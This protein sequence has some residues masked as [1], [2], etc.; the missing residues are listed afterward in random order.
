M[1]ADDLGFGDVGYHGSEIR[2][3]HLDQLARQGMRFTRWYASPS[4]TPTRYSLF[5]GRQPQRSVDDLVVPLMP[6]GPKAEKGAH[7]GIRPN[8]ITLASRL[9]AAGYRT[10]LLGKWHLG[11]G[12]QQFFPTRHGFDLFQGHLS[13]CVDYF[14]LNY[15]RLPDWYVGEALLAQDATQRGRYATDVIGEAAVNYLQAQRPDA[16]FFLTVAFNAPHYGKIKNPLTGK[17]ENDVQAKAEDLAA[18]SYIS[19]DKRRTFAAAV[20]SMDDNIGAILNALKIA[21]LTNNTWIIFTSDNGGHS[22]YG[23]SNKPLRGEKLTLYEGGVRV[24]GFMVWPGQ[25]AP[26][27]ESSQWGSVL[28]VMPTI[29]ATLNLPVIEQ[30]LDGINLLPVLRRG[31]P[32]QRTLYFEQP[33]EA[34]FIQGGWKYLRTGAGAELFDLLHDPNETRNLAAQHPARLG[35]LE[36]AWE[37][38]QRGFKT[39]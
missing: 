36:I 34:A 9:R 18:Y 4:C 39:R 33:G 7:R 19:H 16:P 13:G 1:V 14:T 15:G 26:G 30:P 3:P 20:K 32:M 31:K 25:I 22:P 11:H 24:P 10:A 38:M 37:K 27:V 23:G 21:G 17:N 6:E 28:D 8:E 12:D 29:C 2:T 35:K 5:T